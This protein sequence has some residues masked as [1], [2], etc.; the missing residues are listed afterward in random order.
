M[1]LQMKVQ[2]LLR[3]Q[4]GLKK[5]LNEKHPLAQKKTKNLT[6]QPKLNGNQAPEVFIMKKTKDK[7]SNPNSNL[8]YPFVDLHFKDKTLKKMSNVLY[9]PMSNPEFAYP[10][11]V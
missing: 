5:K 9:R 1:N 10:D 6:N 4:I 2:I 3:K 11:S 8:A 7:K